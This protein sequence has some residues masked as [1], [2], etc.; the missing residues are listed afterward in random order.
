MSN[1]TA[2]AAITKPLGMVYVSWSTSED[3]C[4]RC[5]GE[6]WRAYAVHDEKRD[7]QGGHQQ[8]H[9]HV[10][11]AHPL[12]AMPAAPAQREPRYDWDEIEHSE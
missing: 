8:L 1:H 9:H 11:R 4:E 12:A 7:E 10:A 6:P 3:A 5:V 2:A